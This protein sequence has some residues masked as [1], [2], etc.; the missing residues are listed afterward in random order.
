MAARFL[1]VGGAG[2]I[3]SHMVKALGRAGHDVTTFDNLSLGHRD[4]VV[5]GAFVHGDLRDREGLSRVLTE[6]RFDVVMHFA[7]YAAVGESVANARKYYTNN[8]LGTLNLLHAMLDAG[9]KKFIF[10]SSAATYGSP[11]ETP[12]PETH[13]QDPINP[14]GRTKLMV[15]HILADYAGAHGMDSMSLRYFNAAGADRE[16]Q[17]R[18]RHEPETHLIPLV[19][20]E[21]ERIRTGGDRNAPRLQV[22]GTDYP[23]P[24]GTCLRDYVHVEDLCSAHLAAAQRCLEK[25]H[26]AE[27]CNLGTGQGFSV[28]DII[29]TASAVTGV[30]IPYRVA[31]RRDGDPPSL[32]AAFGRAREL[33]GWA[34]AITSLREIVGSAWAAKSY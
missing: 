2:Y 15:E 3:G 21:A 13:R 5:H 26:G 1:V 27:A 9:T 23:T 17:L 24:D 8:V 33:L 7:A 19:L 20:R 16:G 31:G 11:T 32:V 18:E 29:T 25:S 28:K 22:F 14:Y 34:P 6:G 10:S 4:A 30:D 12:I